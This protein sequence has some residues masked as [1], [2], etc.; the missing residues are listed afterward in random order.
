MDQPAFI[1]AV[2]SEPP[3]I[4]GIK[5][6][7][8]SAGHKLL[9]R[10]FVPI[11]MTPGSLAL[12]VIICSSSYCDGLDAM[13]SSE[14]PSVVSKFCFRV[15]HGSWRNLWRRREIDWQSQW[16]SFCDYVERSSQCPPFSLVSDREGQPSH[17]PELE[18]VKV[19]L[20]K[21]LHISEAEFLDRPWLMSLWDYAAVNEQLGIVRI[22]SEN[23][24]DEYAQS[25]KAGDDFFASEEGRAIIESH[26]A[27]L[28]GRAGE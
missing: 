6:R 10:R 17:C 16:E 13:L 26:R 5:L 22:L 21:N 9:L 14:L 4:L 28:C 19:T 12:A 24:A 2:F 8:Y 1:E 20:M 27:A 7:Q 3:V 11:D 25:Q 23:H 15:T 18:Y